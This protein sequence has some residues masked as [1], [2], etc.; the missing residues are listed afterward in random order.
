M[1]SF[2]FHWRLVGGREWLVD[3]PRVWGAAVHGLLT[4]GEFVKFNIPIIPVPTRGI[5]LT[6]LRFQFIGQIMQSSVHSL[7]RGL[8]DDVDDDSMEG[9]NR[10]R[11]SGKS[12][13]GGG[14]SKSFFV[15]SNGRISI[16]T[17]DCPLAV[18][19]REELKRLS[20]SLTRP[21]SARTRQVGLAHRRNIPIRQFLS[22]TRRNEYSGGKHNHHLSI[23]WFS[24]FCK[25]INQLNNEWITSCLDRNHHRHSTATRPGDAE[26][27]AVALV[28]GERRL[29][30]KSE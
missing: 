27:S 18:E 8:P 5:G 23:F 11:R 4:G 30:G 25:R 22:T 21:V 10:N 2:C 19:G 1:C 16:K 17:N 13:S 6:F 28:A 24:Q 14:K 12:I 3:G 15:K 29:S 26:V 20:M 7:I 9:Q